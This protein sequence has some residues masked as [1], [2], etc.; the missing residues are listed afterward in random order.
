MAIP[1]V[2]VLVPGA[3]IMAVAEAEEE[4]EKVAEEE[5]KEEA[6]EDP[7]LP[8]PRLRPRGDSRPLLPLPR[9]DARL[10]LLRGARRV[11]S[12]RPW[13]VA[14]SPPVRRSL[15]TK[16]ETNQKVMLASRGRR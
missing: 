7:E 2:R 12:A 6:E 4:A 1:G 9:V 15:N 3:V 8:Q 13:T 14:A 16:A 11:S 5:T 10:V